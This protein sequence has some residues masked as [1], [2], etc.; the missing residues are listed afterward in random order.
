MTACIDADTEGQG[1]NNNRMKVIQGAV[2]LSVIL[3]ASL[4]KIISQFWAQF[5]GSIFGLSL[6]GNQPTD[7]DNHTQ[8]TH[9]LGHR[10]GTIVLRGKKHITITA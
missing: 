5:L 8:H 6:A 10:L 4:P 1:E 3:S 2:N 9:R 7:H